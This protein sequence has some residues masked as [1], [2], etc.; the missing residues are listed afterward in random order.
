MNFNIN[1][2]S[3]VEKPIDQSIIIMKS[4]DKAQ[5]NNNYI[6][7]NKISNSKPNVN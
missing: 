6:Y 2:K 7:K 5:S 1:N 4:G 3:V